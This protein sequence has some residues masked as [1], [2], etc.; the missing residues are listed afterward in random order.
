MAR[1][2]KITWAQSRYLINRVDGIRLRIEA[3]EAEDM[4]TKIFAYLTMP[5][6]PGA[7]D[8]VGVFDHICSPVDLEEYPED[9]PIPGHQPG[10][11]RLGYVD[12][13]LRSAAE[14]EAALEAILGD[15]RSLK[16]SLDT[17]DTLEA[18][19]EVWIDNEADPVSSSSE[20]SSEGG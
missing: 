3:E 12:V 6:R 11:F 17:M 10:W 14:I 9:E 2:I 13:L 1:R 18:V 16:R 7:G 19:G 5:L 4:P 20:G 8:P 15:I